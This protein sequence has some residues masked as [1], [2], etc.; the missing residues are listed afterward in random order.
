MFLR[1]K[2]LYIR[3]IFPFRSFPV[4][5]SQSLFRWHV[6]LPYLFC[7]HVW[8]QSAVVFIPTKACTVLFTVTLLKGKIQIVR[9]FLV[10]QVQNSTWTVNL[11]TLMLSRTQ[12][13]N[14]SGLSSCFAAGL[15]KTWPHSCSPD[16]PFVIWCDRTIGAQVTHHIC[17]LCV[18]QHRKAR[19]LIGEAH[20]RIVRIGLQD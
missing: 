6:Y 11:I 1:A 7:Y 15:S 4:K 19:M 5:M 16:G 8:V 18:I 14:V 10:K 12:T 9:V 17:E 2:K 20:I 3:N 13:S